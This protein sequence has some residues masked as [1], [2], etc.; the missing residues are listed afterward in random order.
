[1]RSKSIVLLVLALGCGLV[2]S[3]GISQ[4][5]ERR[6]A[7][8]VGGETE[9]IFVA[10][11]DINYNDL[12][13]PQLIKLEEWPKSKIPQGAVTKLEDTENK[14]C[15]VKMFAGEPIVA[16]KLMGL[17][18]APGAAPQI[19]K[20]FRVVAVQVDGVSSTGGLIQPGDRVDVMVYMARNPATGISQT[21]TR[22]ILQDIKVFAVD[23]SHVGVNRDKEDQLASAKTISL[24]VKPE[25]AEVI[26]LATQIGTIRLSLRSPEDN[27]VAST[28]AATIQELLGI[29]SSN[30]PDEERS[31]PI[32]NSTQPGLLDIL[33]GMKNPPTTSP[34]ATASVAA[35]RKMVVIEGDQMREVLLAA[36]GSVDPGTAAGS[37]DSSSTTNDNS[38]AGD[39]DD[40]SSSPE[41]S[42]ASANIRSAR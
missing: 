14:R 22:T 27:V 11:A 2:A 8:T 1:M 4:V 16:P 13:T 34:G 24:L 28:P 17:N 3:I 37:D 39:S 38:S 30:N 9:A 40:N 36:D 32:P 5:M 33:K 31:N 26:T 42:A 7:S 41:P 29:A 21:N 19:P 25:Q 18:E 10:L 15:R 23:T 35:P 6:N 20:G 12:V